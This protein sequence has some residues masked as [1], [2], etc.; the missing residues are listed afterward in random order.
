MIEKLLSAFDQV[1][2][3]NPLEEEITVGPLIGEGS[4]KT[5]RE[6]LEEI[7]KQGGKILR[8][9]KLIEG[10]GFYVEPTIVEIDS[11]AEIVKEELFVPI[12]YVFKFSSLDEAI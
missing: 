8:G 5:F 9:G 1:K 10:N 6:G 12:L 11:S 7:K 2:I 4:I 3:G